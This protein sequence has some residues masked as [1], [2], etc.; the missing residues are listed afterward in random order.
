MKGG[1]METLSKGIICDRSCETDHAT[2]EAQAGTIKELQ[3]LCDHLINGDK[4]RNKERE[5][6][7]L[8]K[9]IDLFCIS[10]GTTMLLVCCGWCGM[11]YAI[12]DG[13]GVKGVSHGMCDNCFKEQINMKGE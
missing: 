6:T 5:F 1:I 2:L 9:A 11:P 8:T 7:L 13:L 12:K 3:T 4:K 10:A